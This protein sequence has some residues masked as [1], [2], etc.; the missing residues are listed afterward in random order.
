RLAIARTLLQAPRFLLLDEATANL[1]TES[2]NALRDSIAM[3]SGFCAVIAIAHRLSTVT[4]AQQIVVLDRGRVHAVGTHDELH[5]HSDL[6]RRLA[7]LQALS[8]VAS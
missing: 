6:Y 4:E 8:D 7:R 1:D 2:E 3:I 5:R